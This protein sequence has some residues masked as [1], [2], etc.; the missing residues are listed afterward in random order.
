MSGVSSCGIPSDIV[1]RQTYDQTPQSINLKET[2]T[3]V[4]L[5]DLSANKTQPSETFPQPSNRYPKSGAKA[6]DEALWSACPFD[7]DIPPDSDWDSDDDSADDEPV[8]ANVLSKLDPSTYNCLFKIYC[9]ILQSPTEIPSHPAFSDFEVEIDAFRQDGVDTIGN[10]S[11]NIAQ[12]A[13]R[14]VGEGC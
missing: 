3:S 5:L 11:R 13:G 8:S 1:D 4:I 10:L 12:L 6:F 7:D 9:D 2:E 14:L